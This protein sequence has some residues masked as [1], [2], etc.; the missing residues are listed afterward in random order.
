MM[1]PPHG[2]PTH[3]SSAAYSAPDDDDDPDSDD[4]ED[5]P[6]LCYDLGF[7]RDIVSSFLQLPG[8][9]DMPPTSIISIL[10]F[11]MH[12]ESAGLG[13]LYNESQLLQLPGVQ[14]ISSEVLCKLL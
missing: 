11:G 10:R 6:Y 9:Q 1:H 2:V 14:Q 8:T 3:V 5:H 13:L 4:D 7:M 12:S